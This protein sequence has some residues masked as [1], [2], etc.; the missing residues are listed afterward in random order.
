M[1]RKVLTVL[2]AL[3]V[4][5][6]LTGCG[7][8]GG[9][10]T[11]ADGNESKAPK[12]TPTPSFVEKPAVIM[13]KSSVYLRKES[14]IGYNVIT[15]LEVGEPCVWLGPVENSE[16]G[17]YEFYKVRVGEGEDAT[18]GWVSSAFVIPDA[19]P[20]IILE[21][22]V[23]PY[24]EDGSDSIDE[25]L[26]RMDLIAVFDDTS[27]ALD[28]NYLIAFS[29][30][31]KPWPKVNYYQ[32]EKSAVSINIE[33][34]ETVKMLLKAQEIQTE[35]TDAEKLT[36]DDIKKN[37]KIKLKKL[38]NIMKRYSNSLFAE[39]VFD[40]QMEVEQKLVEIE[41]AEKMGDVEP[42]VEEPTEVEPG[43]SL[44]ETDLNE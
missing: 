15:S 12:E 13:Y 8:D 20:G 30:E 42:V 32:V 16:D 21:D 14:E 23:L 34:I 3:I 22:E 9:S 35:S 1:T 27:K 31:S 18:E 24:V 37:L 36:A 43:G 29:S 40:E 33:D 2:L 38:E 25:F 11:T 5:L 6:L 10:S 7:D 39:E 26:N 4:S 17:Q 19:R 28:E 41:T 44:E